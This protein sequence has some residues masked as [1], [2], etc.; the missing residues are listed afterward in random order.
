MLEWILSHLQR[1]H[2]ALRRSEYLYLVLVSILI[3]LLGGLGA[4]GFRELIRLVKDVAWQDGQYTLEYLQ[5]LPV[6]WKVLAPSLGGLFVGLIGYHL[7]REVK[8]H[9]VPEVMEAVALRG[10]RIRPRVVIA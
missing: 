3:G 9:G 7:A 4:V 6:W 10:G 8:G 2:Q 1:F 5:G